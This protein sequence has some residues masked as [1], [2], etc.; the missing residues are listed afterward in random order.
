MN[1]WGFVPAG[2]GRL[3]GNERKPRC[4]A[5]DRDIFPTRLLDTM[6]SHYWSRF[7]SLSREFSYGFYSSSFREFK[8]YYVKTRTFDL[9]SSQEPPEQYFS[10][11][12]SIASTFLLLQVA[13]RENAY[14]YGELRHI[15][16]FY[17]KYRLL[18][19]CEHLFSHRAGYHSACANEYD[20][21]RSLRTNLYETIY[22]IEQPQWFG[23]AVILEH[24]R[25]PDT[26]LSFSTH[27]SSDSGSL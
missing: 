19:L 17:K 5:P 7:V 25:Y 13:S 2:I 3:L 18:D 15:I 24:I 22:L 21:I 12:I 4:F 8:I 14:S 6:Y 20:R 10:F 9:A 16:P 23:I 1:C 11:K 26:S 27:S